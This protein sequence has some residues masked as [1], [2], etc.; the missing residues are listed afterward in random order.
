MK[1]VL[2]WFIISIIL[3]IMALIAV[4]FNNEPILIEMSN[5][6]FKLEGSYFWPIVLVN[7]WTVRKFYKNRKLEKDRESSK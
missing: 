3:T 7:A 1:K 5:G 4:Y 6:G 2:F